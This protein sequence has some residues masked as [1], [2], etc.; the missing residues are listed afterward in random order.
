[1]NE[2]RSRDIDNMAESLAVVAKATRA[3]LPD[4]KFLLVH[5]TAGMLYV[6]MAE[7]MPYLLDQLEPSIIILPSYEVEVGERN[8]MVFR[9]NT[10]GEVFSGFAVTWYDN[11]R[12]SDEENAPLP[13]SRQPTAV[14]FS[15]AVPSSTPGDHTAYLN[16][17]ASQ[18][19][20]LSPVISFVI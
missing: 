10:R 3:Q 16:F 7:L 9:Y 5:P 12:D 13:E 1:M 4:G 8:E 14:S 19:G 15:P 17:T 20:S 6:P 18:S 11:I 2:V